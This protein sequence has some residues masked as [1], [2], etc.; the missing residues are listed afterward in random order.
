LTPS[1][2]NATDFWAMTQI[3]HP[4]L[5]FCKYFKPN[6]V[7][8][9]LSKQFY[10]IWGTFWEENHLGKFLGKLL[11]PEKQSYYQP[12]LRPTVILSG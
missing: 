7:L 1:K 2:K 12:D 9:V 11:V 4:S 5:D 6:D 8:F 10:Y 3:C